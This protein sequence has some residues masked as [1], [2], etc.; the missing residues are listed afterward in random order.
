MTMIDFEKMFDLEKLKSL[1][2]EER[3]RLY[4]HKFQFWRLCHY[5]KCRRARCCRGE[6]EHCVRKFGDWATEVRR[7]AE[8]ELAARDPHH[9]A[10]VEDMKQRVR[11]LS[12][13]MAAERIAPR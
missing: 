8:C 2:G 6:L 4:A 5:V 7:A 3:F 9:Q 13:T 1:S 12:Q 11:R 10:L